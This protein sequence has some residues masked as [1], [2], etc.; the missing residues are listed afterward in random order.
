MGIREENFEDINIDKYYY[1]S[2]FFSLYKRYSFAW[3][4]FQIG[5]NYGR[6]VR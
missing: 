6:N 4:V 5:V 1:F 2:M 3:N